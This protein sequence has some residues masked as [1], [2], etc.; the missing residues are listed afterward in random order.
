MAASSG[1]FGFR[2]DVA[3]LRSISS[4]CENKMFDEYKGF[5]IF[6]NVLWWL[7]L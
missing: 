2:G 1:S 4:S 7:T 3:V 6:S 5:S